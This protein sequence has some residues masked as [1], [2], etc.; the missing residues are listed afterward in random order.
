MFI[1]KG[2]MLI[3]ECED[4]NG[5]KFEKYSLQPLW[6]KLY[7]IFR[8]AENQKNERTEEGEQKSLYTIFE[9]EFA[10]PFLLWNVRR[11]RSGRTRIIMMH[12]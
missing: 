5:I 8:L 2:F 12:N 10:R 6:G 7:E 1:Q 4:Q 11:W 3:E 9:E